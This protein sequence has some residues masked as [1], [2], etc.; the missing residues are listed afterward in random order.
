[1]IPS[2]DAAAS[3]RIRPRDCG[4]ARALL[5]LSRGS[6]RP[7]RKTPQRPPGQVPLPQFSEH[8]RSAG[9]AAR[10]GTAAT[11]CA[12][13]QSSP[14]LD[15]LQ[16]R[17]K[18]LQTIRSEQKKARE[19]EANLRREI[20]RIGDD[21]RK[22]NR[23]LIDVAARVR[24][25]EQ[26]IAAGEQRL[27]P[28]DEKERTLRTSLD[29]PPPP[30]RQ[31]AGGAATHRPQPAAGDAG[32]AGRRAAIGALG[33]P[34]RR[35]AAGDAPGRR[36]ARR[37]PRRRW[38]RCARRSR[39]SA[40]SLEKSRAA[41][42]DDHSAAHRPDRA[43]PEAAGR[44]RKSAHRRAPARGATGAAVRG[45]AGTDRQARAGTRP[46]DSRGARWPPAAAR[47]KRRPT[48][49]PT[50]PPSRTPAGW[51]PRSPLPGPRELYRCL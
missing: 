29:A 40:P 36:G 27:P 20:E 16:Q 19:R 10:A 47:K 35:G 32:D 34:V 45:P 11:R 43:P 26:Q 41:L 25:I 37:R 44:S 23:Q 31:C 1:M 15:A 6:S 24:T 13:R 7:P 2:S 9:H 12:G 17:D 30:H 21:R 48:P 18:E 38:Q 50:W 51:P 22:L 14:K 3:P 5:A 33:D 42:A 4:S 39:P 49:A 8:R 46:H 28:L